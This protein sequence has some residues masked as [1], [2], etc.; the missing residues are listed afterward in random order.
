MFL[1]KLLVTLGQNR[2]WF[3]I[4]KNERICMQK[5]AFVCAWFLVSRAAGVFAAEPELKGTAAELSQ[6]LAN[7]PKTVSVVGEAQ[8]KVAAERAIV[9]LKVTAES[10]A[11][12]EA[13][14]ANQESRLKLLTQLKKQEI[15]GERVQESKFS[16]TP[17]F[18]WFGE[19]AKSYRVENLVKVTVQD[20]REFQVVAGMVDNLPE[21]QFVGA[22]FEAAD[23]EA[24]KLKAASMA[25]DSAGARKKV[26]EEKLGMKLTPVRF[27]AGPVSASRPHLAMSDVA[28][29][30]KY[31][32]SVGSSFSSGAPPEAEE[33][34]T[35]FGELVFNAEVI[36]EY[37]V[38]SR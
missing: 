31:S 1:L 19:K 5:T 15:P 17:K 18:G 3:D 8:L 10:K 35:S 32:R 34:P 21:V 27:S 6:Y 38:Q 4:L 12:R 28:G 22:D 20:E 14:R 36:V 13:L 2:L 25:C 23:K 37:Q 29:E 16:S 30:G 11:L 9:S 26:Y 24:L 7:V 33:A